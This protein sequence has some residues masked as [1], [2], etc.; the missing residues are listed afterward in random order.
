MK[1]TPLDFPCGCDMSEV[2]YQGVKLLLNGY[3]RRHARIHRAG[4][5]LDDATILGCDCPGCEFGK[6]A[7][8]REPTTQPDGENWKALTRIHARRHRKADE[9]RARRRLRTGSRAR[10]RRSGP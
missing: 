8:T 9:R 7:S 1:V 6:Y 5:T 2:F 10:R 4:I 3:C